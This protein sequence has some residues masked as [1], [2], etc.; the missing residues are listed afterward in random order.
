LANNSTDAVSGTVSAVEEVQSNL[1]MI[2]EKVKT[3][4]DMNSSIAVATEEQSTVAEQMN[5]SL[6]DI[7]SM[8]EDTANDAKLMSE[9]II[10]VDT[11]VKDINKSVSRF[12]V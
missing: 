7:D 2:I 9:S 10:Q 8:S 4:S 3:I 6:V 1:G 12:K 11:M 5:Q